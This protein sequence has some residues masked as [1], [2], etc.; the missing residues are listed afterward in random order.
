MKLKSKAKV[1]LLQTLNSDLKY[2]FTSA[3]ALTLNTDSDQGKDTDL[4]GFGSM[5]KSPQSVRRNLYQSRNSDI[6]SRFFT[7]TN[8]SKGVSDKHFDFTQFKLKQQSIDSYAH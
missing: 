4:E 6:K 2:G 3:E 7:T 8:Q 5:M 1:D